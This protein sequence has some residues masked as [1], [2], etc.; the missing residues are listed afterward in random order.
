MLWKFCFYQFN[1]AYNFESLVKIG[2][3]YR[4]GGVEDFVMVDYGVDDWFT[5]VKEIYVIPKG[6]YLG[7][8][9]YSY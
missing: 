1:V 3:I 2:I 8:T 5:L 6:D 4:G 7:S 9:S